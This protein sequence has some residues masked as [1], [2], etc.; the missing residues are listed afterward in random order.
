MSEQMP[1]PDNDFANPIGYA[2]L[3]GFAAFCRGA[4]AQ[5]DLL[6]ER[7]DEIS[8]PICGGSG[9]LPEAKQAWDI[10]GAPIPECAICKGIGKFYRLFMEEK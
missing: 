10:P 8:C 6:L 7:L 2:E 4:K 1:E 3:L 9:E 5:R